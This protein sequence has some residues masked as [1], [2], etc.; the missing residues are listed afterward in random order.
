LNTA[1]YFYQFFK[2]LGTF[3][4]MLSRSYFKRISTPEGRDIIKTHLYVATFVGGSILWALE[5]RSRTVAGGSSKAARE[6][7][8][9]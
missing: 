9:R 4:F 3:L 7:A 6:D 5:V 1:K 2:M 8:A